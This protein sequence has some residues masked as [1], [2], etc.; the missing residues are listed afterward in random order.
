MKVSAKTGKFLWLGNAP[1]IDFVNTQIV[2]GGANL[3]LLASG[4]DF[5]SW[6]RQSWLVQAGALPRPAAGFLAHALHAARQYRRLLREGL[7]A[8]TMS[9]ELPEATLSATNAL[10]ASGARGVRLRHR[11]RRWVMEEVWSFA[12]P[13]MLCAPI[14]RAF[15]ELLSRAEL[16]RIRA[17]RNPQCVLF[18]YDSS[19][20]GTRAWCSL[21]TCGNKLRVAA[22]RRRKTKHKAGGPSHLMPSHPGRPRVD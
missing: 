4:E 11:G 3:D 5:L 2:Q 14:A 1:A 13:S 8:L 19:K 21:G 16:G 9:G 22:F 15:A 10:L 7:E 18:F 6:L 20:S 12:E 17:C